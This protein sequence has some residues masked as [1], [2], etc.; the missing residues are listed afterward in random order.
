MQLKNPFKKEGTQYFFFSGKGGVGKTS[1]AA[2]TATKLSQEKKV[3]IISTDPAHSLS[4]SFEEKIGE[5]EKKIKENLFA[6]EINPQEALKEYKEKVAGKI[7][8][9]DCLKDMGLE[10]T[11]GMADMSPG[12]D[13]IAAFDKFLQFMH[14]EEYQVI[15]F[16]T[17]PTGHALRF[18][19]LPDVLESWAGK[20]IK[21]RMRLS[22][23]VSSV[24]KF[25]PFGEEEEVQDLGAE[26]L[27]AMKE[28]VEEAKKILSDP[29]RTHFWLVSIAEEMS[30]FESERAK[31]TLKK[32]NIPVEGVIV[33][34]L[35]PEESGENCDFCRARREMQQRN[36]EKIQNKFNDLEIKKIQL[37]KH[38]VKG[39]KTLKKLA[40]LLYPA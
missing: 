36:L 3:L 19:S 39:E 11:I 33:N 1:I 7:K 30:I 23:L 12:V 10:E 32:Y 16:D 37:L 40:G 25:L 8:E 15:I 2:A 29:K 35:I 17:A 34:Q 18:L 24:R 26:Q 4:D 21:I 31:K 14:S 27:E 38:E 13:E 28:R 9:I 5:K 20:L 22:S 6:V